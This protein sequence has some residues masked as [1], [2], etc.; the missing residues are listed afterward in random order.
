MAVD[1][2]LQQYGADD[3]KHRIQRRPSGVY[4]GMQK[5][6]RRKTLDQCAADGD[7]LVKEPAPQSIVFE[8]HAPRIP[9]YVGVLADELHDLPSDD[10]LTGLARFGQGY[11]GKAPDLLEHVRFDGGL[12]FAFCLKV[13]LD[14]TRGNAGSVSYTADRS[15]RHATIR[16][17][18]ERRVT[19]SRIGGEV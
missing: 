3:H 13:M 18:S 1:S 6:L 14:Q 9:N 17:Q 15:S 2:R 12:Q 10:E 7:D 5:A 11:S 8:Y 4:I 19:D 16:K